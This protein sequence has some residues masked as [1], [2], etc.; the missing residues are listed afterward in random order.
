MLRS[1]WWRCRRKPSPPPPQPR[2]PTQ[3]L[4]Q[5]LQLQL[6]L[7]R[8]PPLLRLLQLPLTMT[9]T[10]MMPTTKPARRLMLPRHQVP[11]LPASGALALAQDQVLLL[12]VLAEADKCV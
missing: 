7:E 1:D 10:M 3:H 9:T 11:L 5:Q 8:L 4:H 6:R 2:Q 12:R